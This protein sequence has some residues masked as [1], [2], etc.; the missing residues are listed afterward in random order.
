MPRRI[1]HVLTIALL[2]SIPVLQFANSLVF[3]SFWSLEREA[4]KLG[5]A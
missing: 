1:R 2:G 4:L 5:A 3:L